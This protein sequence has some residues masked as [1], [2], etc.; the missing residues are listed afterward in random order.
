MDEES[1]NQDNNEKG[2]SGNKFIGYKNTSL[3]AVSDN[4]ATHRKKKRLTRIEKAGRHIME[5][6][7]ELAR[8]TDM[9]YYQM[10]ARI[11]EIYT[12][13]LTKYDVAN[14]FNNN[15]TALEQLAKE[16]DKL[17]NFRAKLYLDHNQVLVKDIKMLDDQITKL[18]GED[19]EMMNAGHRA[20]VIGELI[21]KKG[22][23][24]LRHARL[25]G[26]VPESTT[27]IDKMQINVYQ[28]L[29]EEKS[30]IIERLKRVR[31]N[32]GKGNDEKKSSPPVI[33]VPSSEVKD[34][35]S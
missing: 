34:E 33:D 6:L 30:D 13:N 2:D 15:E 7:I 31:F 29:Q 5:H 19:G 27:T 17:I 21:D 24:L 4:Y 1:G 16:D 20:K 18:C 14:F 28:Q 22:K 9:S 3:S 32:N 12:L 26:K 8:S 10:S 35:N 23:L 11:N 25:A